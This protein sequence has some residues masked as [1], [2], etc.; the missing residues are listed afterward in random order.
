TQPPTFIAGAN[1]PGNLGGIPGLDSISSITVQASQAG[2]NYRF[3]QLL[4]PSKLML[5]SSTNT[6]AIQALTGA[7][8]GTGVASVTDPFGANGLATGGHYFVTGAGFGHSP[9]V[10]VYNPFTGAQVVQF[11]AY[12][13]RF[14]GG[15]RVALGDVNGDGTPDIVTA[16][17]PTA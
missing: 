13:P 5:L 17:G 1:F 15:V 10:T 8:A 7:P 2:V 11:N 9:V 16:T 4:P 6:Q 3:T 14:Q 12:D